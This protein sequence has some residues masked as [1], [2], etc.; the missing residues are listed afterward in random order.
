MPQAAQNRMEDDLESLKQEFL[1]AVSSAGD[2][3]ALD[4][5]RVSALGKKGRITELMKTLGA[6]PPEQRKELNVLDKEMA[7]RLDK[8]LS[9]LEDNLEASARPAVPRRA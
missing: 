2:A 4:E 5:V 8:I 7:G 6:L 3:I 9:R 1:T